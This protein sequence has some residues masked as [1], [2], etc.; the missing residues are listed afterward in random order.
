MDLAAKSGVPYPTLRT[1]VPPD[2]RKPS[3]HNGLAISA[4]LCV[5]AEWLFGED[6]SWPPPPRVQSSS[7]HILFGLAPLLLDI[8]HPGTPTEAQDALRASP[9]IACTVTLA[10]L[11]EQTLSDSEA[12]TLREAV[13]AEV[14]SRLKTRRDPAGFGIPW[15]TLVSREELQAWAAVRVATELVLSSP[16]RFDPQRTISSWRL[17]QPLYPG[18]GELHLGFSDERLRKWS[19]PGVAPERAERLQQLMLLNLAPARIKLSGASALSDR[20]DP[21]PEVLDSVTQ[22]MK[23]SPSR[24][25]AARAKRATDEGR[26]GDAYQWLREAQFASRIF[27]MPELAKR[28]LGR[29][30][31][32]QQ[33]F[34]AHWDEVSE[35]LRRPL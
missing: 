34:L 33:E 12:E 29:G 15:E 16:A 7:H 5:P 3:I 32:T 10:S 25:R 13:N 19:L 24:L 1:Y 8:P 28:L 30:G 6:D 9:A 27:Q 21:P 11:F 31:P 20:D 26:T 23:L 35:V 18:T 22:L 4:A 14:E 2:D 17:S